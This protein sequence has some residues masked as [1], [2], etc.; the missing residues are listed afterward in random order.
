[1]NIHIRVNGSRVMHA[2]LRAK[3]QSFTD[4]ETMKK[5]RT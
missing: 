4:P 3:F 5:E 2:A 1:L